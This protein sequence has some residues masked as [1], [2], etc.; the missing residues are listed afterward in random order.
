MGRSGS[1]K[2]RQGGRVPSSFDDLR[3]ADYNP[4]E[5]SD[6][7][8]AGLSV[9]MS[10]FGDISGITWNQ[11]SGCIVSGHQRVTQLRAAGA[12]FK[13]SRGRVSLCLGDSVFP[14]RVVDLDADEERAA[15]L[16]ANN[17]RIAG[18]WTAGVEELL[19]GVR[20]W[21]DGLFEKLNL[22]NLADDLAGQFDDVEPEEDGASSGMVTAKI[23]IPKAV[24]MSRRDGL[25]RSMDKSAKRFGV[26]VSWPD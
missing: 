7:A 14:V 10:R 18:D 11:R 25:M 3:A 24:W 2:R 9:S 8:G 23:E 4:R 20:E 22:D 19:A 26:E 6:E 16:A 17:A 21:D 13:N 15:N 5:M 12:V 1:Q